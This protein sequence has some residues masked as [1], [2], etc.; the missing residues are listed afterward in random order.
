MLLHSGA[1]HTIKL[2]VTLI[3]DSSVV[4]EQHDLWVSVKLHEVTFSH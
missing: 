1:L 3:K 4:C 2:C